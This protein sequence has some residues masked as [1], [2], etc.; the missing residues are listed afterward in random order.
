M[1][2]ART[3]D[4][5]GNVHTYSNSKLD[6]FVGKYFNI[7]IIAGWISVLILETFWGA[8]TFS[9]F[10]IRYPSISIKLLLPL[11]FS[12]G[13]IFY[14]SLIKFAYKV[15]FDFSDE[16]ITLF[17][18]KKRSPISFKLN[19]LKVIRINWFICF[20]FNN[21]RTIWYKSDSTF[22]RFLIKFDI[23]R[24]WGSVGKFFMK[25]EFELDTLK[26]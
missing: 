20:V 10:K 21:G 12:L 13:F 9:K 23:N 3:R 2:K 26:K 15:V 7:I 22:L 17:F 5:R 25:K 18:Y 1:E 4:S 24:E 8:T 19:E 6:I 11:F 14:I 16:V